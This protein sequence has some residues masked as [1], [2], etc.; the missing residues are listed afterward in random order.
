MSLLEPRLLLLGEGPQKSGGSRGNVDLLIPFAPF[1]RL[2]EEI[3]QYYLAG[4]RFQRATIYA[5]Q[6][7]A[8]S[9]LADL[10]T[11]KLSL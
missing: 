7:A 2:V 5:L 11:G 10:L 8:E 1:A 6:Q 3:S 9:M 4:A